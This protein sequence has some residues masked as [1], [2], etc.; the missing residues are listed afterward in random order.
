MRVAKGG[1]GVAG[2]FDQG[3]GL[4]LV[5]HTRHETIAPGNNVLERSVLC[6]YHA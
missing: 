2:D 3:S 5:S 4:D 1:G 6:R